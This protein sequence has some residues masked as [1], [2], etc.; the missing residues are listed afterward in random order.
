MTDNVNHPPHYT[1]GGLECIEAM[2][3][4]LGSDAVKSFCLCN[5]FK[6][7]WRSSNKNGIE[8]IQK[9]NWYLAKYLDLSAEEMRNEKTVELPNV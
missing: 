7:I 2:V 4:A 3:A 9:A 6:Y 8:D 5:A 1:S